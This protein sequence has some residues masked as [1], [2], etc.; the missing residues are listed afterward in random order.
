VSK[1][2]VGYF[3]PNWEFRGQLVFQTASSK[4]TD[5]VYDYYVWNL[6]AGKMASPIGA[7]DIY[8]FATSRQIDVVRYGGTIG[9]IKDIGFH[10]TSTTPLGYSLQRKDDGTW[11]HPKLNTKGWSN[12]DIR[13][14]EFHY[15][16][17]G[18]DVDEFVE[19]RAKLGLGVSQMSVYYLSATTGQFEP[20]SFYKPEFYPFEDF[21]LS[22]KTSDGAYDYY[23]WNLNSDKLA[24]KAGAIFITDGTPFTTLDIVNYGGY[25][26]GMNEH[27]DIGVTETST[28]PVGHSLQ[29]KDDRTWSA[30]ANT[31]GAAN[32][33]KL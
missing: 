1:L 8:D 12:Y 4:A 17:T 9:G 16:N 24:P 33:A 27:N 18:S 30:K 14:N 22:S 15:E 31:K 3:G 10:E 28:T 7:L 11:F 32:F 13:V 6:P 20:L 26:G 2:A 23:V 5:G 25:D 29:C 19:V 21:Y